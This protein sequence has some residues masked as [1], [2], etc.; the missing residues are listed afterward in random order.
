MSGQTSPRLLLPRSERKENLGDKARWK[1]QAL[2]RASLNFPSRSV[3]YERTSH[4]QIPT[5]PSIQRLSVT[6]P[7]DRL[8]FS[9]PSRQCSVS[10]LTSRRRVLDP[11]PGNGFL[12]SKSMNGKRNF[13][14]RK[15]R[16]VARVAKTR[17]NAIE[18]RNRCIRLL[19]FRE[20]RMETSCDTV[21]IVLAVS[22]RLEED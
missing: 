20:I 12:D 11:V 21:A 4:L 1:E 7:P 2:P 15:K 22:V 10:P 16:F 17:C 19:S 3:D 13:P 8:F 18:L 14:V 9:L 5:L 6:S